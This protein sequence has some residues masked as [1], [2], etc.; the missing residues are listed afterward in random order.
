[1]RPRRLETFKDLLGVGDIAAL[2]EKKKQIIP[3]SISIAEGADTIVWA[4]A[5]AD[6]QVV[7]GSNYYQREQ[8]PW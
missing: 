6:G 5:A 8:Q 2:A 4:A 3:S 1:M 7:S